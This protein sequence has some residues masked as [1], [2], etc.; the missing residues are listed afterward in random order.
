MESNDLRNA[1]LKVTHPRVRILE[2]LE[3]LKGKHVTAEDI[4]RQLLEHND[5]IGLATVYRVLTQF[6]A[7]GLVLKHNF[8]GGQAV[9]ELDR[10]NHHDHMIDVES[11]KVIEFTSE[12]IERLQHEIA[13]KYGYQIEDHSLVLYVRPKRKG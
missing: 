2:I 8:E 1:G 4:Y 9:Y 10:G 12:E 7:A 13:A 11:G 3:T 6:E 5:D